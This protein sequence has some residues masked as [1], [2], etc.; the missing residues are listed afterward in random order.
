MAEAT[1]RYPVGIQTFEEVREQ[2][3]LYID[4]TPFIYALAHGSGKTY[5]L[6]RPRR[7]GKSLLLSTMQAYFEGRRGL[8]EGLAV[9]ELET[10]WEAHPV[11]RLDLS[12]VKTEDAGQ[13]AE[14]LDATLRGLEGTWGRDER[15]VTPGSRLMALIKAAHAQAG[16]KVVV[17]VDEYDAPL[18]NVAHDPAKLHAFR[19]VM[20]EFFAPLKACDE[21]LRF[22]FLTG[23]TKFSQL[24]IFSELNNLT[25]LSLDP[26]FSAICGITEEELMG[27]MAPD[28]DALAAALGVTPDEALACLKANYDGYH[29]SEASPDIYNP[30]SLL[31]SFASGKIGSY[32]FGSGTPTVVVNLLRESGWDI[33]D[34]EGREADEDEFDAPA[35]DMPTPLPMLY[36]AGYLTI[37]S[38]DP[39]TCSYTLGIPNAEVARGLSKSLVRHE[40]GARTG[41]FNS[42]VRTVS[43]GLRAHDMEGV[44]EATRAFM[45]GMPYH[46]GSHNERGFQTTFWLIFTLLGAQ[47][48][49]EVKTAT[50]RVDAVVQ[51]PDA[52]YVMEFKYEKSAREA[53]AQIDEKGYLV[54]FSADGRKL[55]KVGV[56]FSEKTQTIEE[57][58][59][60]EACG[61]EA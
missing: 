41:E 29:F 34:L 32:W 19:L 59:I 42:L 30:F 17:L 2:G 37:K 49:T 13:L 55:Y 27:R 6:S 33:C 1:H 56:N 57:W 24:S 21:H 45:A 60:R 44:L 23:I 3:Y 50:G 20:R 51:V 46:L 53:L 4:K 61:G 10:E 7:F 15:D 25:N 38:Y 22:V 5:F 8:F 40:A 54:P 47:I 43:R 11:I 36:Q 31:S 14:L 9:A 26:R 58:V 12:T 16:S 48:E 28:V 18:L 52:V 39:L 35:E